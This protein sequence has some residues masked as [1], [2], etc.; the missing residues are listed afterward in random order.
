MLDG[1]HKGGRATHSAI[2]GT[3]DSLCQSQRMC[4]KMLDRVVCVLGK[5]WVHMVV[6]MAA[7]CNRQ[8]VSTDPGSLMV[9]EQNPGYSLYCQGIDMRQ[10]N[11]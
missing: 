1:E 8:R 5:Y 11:R 3:I 6:L 2:V 7:A 9:K 4:V 10:V